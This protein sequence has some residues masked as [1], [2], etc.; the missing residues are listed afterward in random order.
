[1]P[2]K[3]K[4]RTSGKLLEHLPPTAIAAFTVLLFFQTAMAKNS[5]AET[6]RKMYSQRIRDV[7]DTTIPDD[8]LKL[9]GEIFNAANA[10]KLS[11]ELR[12]LMCD[13]VYDLASRWSAGHR[14][15]YNAMNRLARAVPAQTN[16]CWQMRL[17]LLLNR[18]RSASGARQTQ[19]A[20][21]DYVGA[22]KA[23]S[24]SAA[25]SGKYGPAGIYMRKALSV[26]TDFKMSGIPQMRLQAARFAALLKISQKR[27]ALEKKLNAKPG[28]IKIREQLIDFYV[29]DLDDPG[30]AS[31]ILNDD[32]D[33][34]LRTYVKLAAG[35]L[36][37]LETIALKELGEWYGQLADR[38]S[39]SSKAAM[40]RRGEAC[41]VRFL[42]VYTKKDTTRIKAALALS[43]VRRELKKLGV[44]S[45][46]GGGVPRTVKPTLD[47]G[48]HK[49]SAS[50]PHRRKESH[51]RRRGE[52]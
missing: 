33:E 44:G 29:I 24:E 22:L 41:W 21:R 4:T 3:A 38:A 50:N 30:A 43:K 9:A 28:D 23:A 14:L 10:R 8:D 42:A 19:T 1:M 26:A 25:R 2:R 35:P 17:E 11:D 7:K 46:R 27:D 39:V 32:C 6:F 15:A 49:D 40:L 37:K 12:I 31:K 18:L 47:D 48:K 20:A 16:H 5:P 51:P 34:L 13:A 36:D 52:E 45:S